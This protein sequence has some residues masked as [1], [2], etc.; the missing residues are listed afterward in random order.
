MMSQIGP[1]IEDHD[2]QDSVSDLKS[3]L[4]QQFAESWQEPIFDARHVPMT[5]RDGAPLKG[6]FFFCRNADHSN[7]Q[8]NILFSIAQI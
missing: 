2:W 1:Y 7:Y 5:N 4:P 8:N 6:V 3:G